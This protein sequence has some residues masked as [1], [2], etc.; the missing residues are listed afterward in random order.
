MDFRNGIR[1]KKTG[2]SKKEKLPFRG[3]KDD[4]FQ[5]KE[6]RKSFFS[7]T[8][9][10]LLWFARKEILEGEEKERTREKER[11]KFDEKRKGSALIHQ[12]SFPPS[13]HN[14]LVFLSFLSEERERDCEKERERDCEKERERETL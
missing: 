6:E 5:G 3:I 4:F 12:V 13:F 2:M 8:S 1:G 7:F 9:F 11:K 10:I 14:F